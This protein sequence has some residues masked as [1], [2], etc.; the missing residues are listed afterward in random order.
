MSKHICP[1]CGGTKFETTAHVMQA[2]EVNESGEFID[3]I[4]D[5]L[6]VTHKPDDGNIWTCT[7]CGA[8]AVVLEEHETL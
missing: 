8:E 6:Q 7:K 3:V 5:C 1:R 4:V 2:W